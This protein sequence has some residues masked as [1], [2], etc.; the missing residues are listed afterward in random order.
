MHPQNTVV[1]ETGSMHVLRFIRSRGVVVIALI[2]CDILHAEN[3]SRV[4]C[5]LKI[6]RTATVMKINRGRYRCSKSTTY[7][8][9]D[10][11][12]KC[13]L[14]SAEEWNALRTAL[15]EACA[16]S[17]REIHYRKGRCPSQHRKPR[18]RRRM[19]WGLK[20]SLQQSSRAV[21]CQLPSQH[22]LRQRCVLFLVGGVVNS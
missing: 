2:F 14:W 11:V 8:P 22:D 12:Q 13:P 15:F 17:G 10:A 3:E 1:H 6:L 9:W 7:A 16:N 20:S 21:V 5:I 4:L 18:A 19:I